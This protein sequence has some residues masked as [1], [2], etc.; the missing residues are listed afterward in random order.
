MTWFSP[1]VRSSFCHEAFVWR[2]TTRGELQLVGVWCY[3][4]WIEAWNELRWPRG[5]SEQLI[6]IHHVFPTF[7]PAYLI[8][9]EA[10]QFFQS[11]SLSFWVHE[12]FWGILVPNTAVMHTKLS[13]CIFL[14]QNCIIHTNIICNFLLLKNWMTLINRI[15]METFDEGGKR[16]DNNRVYIDNVT[17]KREILD[18]YM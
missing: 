1:K 17:I 4:F 6:K 13:T 18:D 14:W 11:E 10:F 3:K 5:Q 2:G 15:F 16:T 12:T 9:K 8:E 7:F